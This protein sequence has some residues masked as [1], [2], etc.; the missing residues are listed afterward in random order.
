[1][2]CNRANSSEIRGQ[3]LKDGMISMKNDGMRKVEAGVTTPA[4]V[5]RSA[6]SVD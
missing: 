5:L 2:V 3:A 1:L 6:Y 4:E